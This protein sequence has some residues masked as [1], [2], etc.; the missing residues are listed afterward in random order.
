MT[1]EL[2]R[3]RLLAENVGGAEAI[4]RQ[5][6]SGRL[7]APER[8]AALLDPGTDVPFGPLLHADDLTQI[9]RTYGDGE[10]AGFGKIDGR[11]VAYFA[12]DPRVKGASGTPATFRH[13]DA[14]RRIAERAALPVIHLMQGGGAR[15]TDAMSSCFLAFPGTGLGA[16]RAFPRRGVLITA[17]LGNYFAPWTVAQA[18]FSVMTESSNISLTAPP[19]VKVGTGQDVTAAELGGSEVQARITG[20]IDSVV[21]DDRAAL[22]MVR[23]VMSYLPSRAGVPAPRGPRFS[24]QASPSLRS[25]VPTQLSLAYDIRSVIT[26]VVDSDSFLEWAPRFA[27]NMVTGLARVDGRTVVVLANQPQALAGVIDVHAV[28]KAS[29]IT[30]LAA[31]F[32]L[33]V[34]TFIDTP[35]VLPTKEQE[36]ARLMTALFDFATLRL[37]VQAPKVSIVVRKGIGYAVQ[38]MSAGDPEGLTLA[39]PDA[40]IAFTGPEAAARITFRKEIEQGASPS[41][42]ASSFVGRSAPWE[43]AHL[44]YLDDIIDPAD[45]RPMLARALS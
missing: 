34:V 22:E 5:H 43:A 41:E 40:Q 21:P 33:P 39:W 31:D 14:F 19:L 13:C 26:E 18:D 27:P 44:G 11:W 30:R 15:M 32:S 4:E 45:T 16:R 10:L 29:K 3:R 35:G 7:T 8:V 1:T 38:A 17:V 12:S 24:L 23:R 25:I 6:A 42:L 2:L 28:T 37:T 20:Q 36:H 9:E